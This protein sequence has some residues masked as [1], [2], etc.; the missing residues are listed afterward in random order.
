VRPVNLL[1]TRYRPAR[2][3]GARAGIGYIAIGTLAVLLLMVLAYVV[4]DNGI[5]DANEKTARAQAEAQE[6]QARAGAL[7]A[8]GSFAQLKTSRESAVK[9]I[10]Q[11][12]FDYERLMRET[13]LV[14][15]KD[16]YLT[17]FS[18]STGG[19]AEAAAAAPTG[20]AT[21]SGPTVSVAGCAPSHPDVAATIVRLRQMHNVVDVNLKSSTKAA[22]VQGTGETGAT[23]CKVAWDGT[24]EFEP[25]APAT[26]PER[27]P[28]RLGGGQ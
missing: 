4:T 10:A 19:E 22:E 3:T 14:L 21:A 16:V 17:T 5:K 7:A 27:V 25:E 2:A 28:A 12:R 23:V 1:P 20:Q 26:E 13:A 8:Y 18:A 24:V 15:P 6:A 9:G 11:V